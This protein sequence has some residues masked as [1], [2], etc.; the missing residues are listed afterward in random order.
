MWGAMDPRL[1]FVHG[2]GGPQQ[3]EEERDRWVWALAEGTRRAGRSDVAADLVN[4]PGIF[5]SIRVLPRSCSISLK[6]KGEAN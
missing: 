5:G 4:D 1:V 6:H 3:V 2:I